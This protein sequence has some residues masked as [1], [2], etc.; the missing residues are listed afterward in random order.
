MAFDKN[1]KKLLWGFVALVVVVVGLVVFALVTQFRPSG[2]EKAE[3]ASVE[4]GIPDGVAQEI[5]DRKSEAF[6]GKVS[7]EEYFDGLGHKA[8]A[9]DEDISLVSSAPEAPRASSSAAVSGSEGAA[10]RVFG[11]A[12]SAPAAAPRRSSGGVAS[13]PMSTDEKLDYDRRRAEMVRDV[14]TGGAAEE[15]PEQVGGDAAAAAEPASIDLS[16]V[17]SSEGIISTLDDDFSDA[18]V[19]YEGAK[20]P[21][22]CMFVRDQK[23]KSGQRVTLRLLEDYVDG[24]V[25]IPANTHLAAICKLGDRLELSVRSLEMNGR[26]VPLALDAYDTDG[27]QGIYCPETSA[28]KNSRQASNDAISA[29]GTTFG[30]LVGD[31]AS[32]VLRT[33]ASIARSASGEV[34]VSVVSGYEFYLVKSERK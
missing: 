33:G 24:G 5:A 21:F 7:T 32:T 29:A 25:R 18:A 20:R 16:A 34:S 23:L 26:I 6:R 1:N 19:Q 9:A 22:R 12:P 15:T 31:L 13:R 27:L 3:R 11:P 10:E 28:S 2:G 17:G 14:L 4:V 8:G 30:G